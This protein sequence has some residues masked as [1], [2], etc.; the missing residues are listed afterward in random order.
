M[1]I[2]VRNYNEFDR[3]ILWEVGAQWDLTDYHIALQKNCALLA[4]HFPQ[5][6]DVMVD[7]R[8]TLIFPADVVHAIIR[9]HYDDDFASNYGVCVIVSNTPI[10]R[11][12]F[13][14]FSA[15]PFTRDRILLADSTEKAMTVIQRRRL[16]DGSGSSGGSQQT[17]SGGTQSTLAQVSTDN[18]MMQ[19]CVQEPV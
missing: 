2:D 13:S 12:L 9:R 1:T 17:G 16:A 11:A 18:V 4:I 7:M 10:V 6:A 3:V 8:H 15:S 5:R 19:M 14:I